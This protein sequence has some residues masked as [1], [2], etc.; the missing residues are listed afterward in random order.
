MSSKGIKILPGLNALKWEN[1]VIIADLHLGFDHEYSGYVISKTII[2][3]VINLSK[4]G[5]KLIILGDFKDKIFNIKEQERKF[6]K[7]AVQELISAYSEICIVK[8]NHDA[9]LEQVL[10]TN[11][12]LMSTRGMRLRNLVFAHGHAWPHNTEDAR[13]IIFG[14]SHP[15]YAIKEYPGSPQIPVFVS[16]EIKEDLK[17]RLNADPKVIVLPAFNQYLGGTNIVERG[18]IDVFYMYGYADVRT[19]RVYSNE[20]LEILQFAAE[21]ASPSGRGRN[22]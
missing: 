2:Q 16:Y 4:Y 18:L 20:G 12:I 21:K 19:I 10:D 11:E 17:E 1:Y 22:F 8:G 6:L 3:E 5:K 9:L 7:N 14:H 13:F 15:V